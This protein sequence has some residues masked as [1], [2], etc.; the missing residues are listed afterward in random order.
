M[1]ENI[2]AI[3]NPFS[4]KQIGTENN[5][6][7]FVYPEYDTFEHKFVWKLVN[8]NDEGMPQFTC[9]VDPETVGLRFDLVTDCL[10][11]LAYMM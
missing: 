3:N 8:I 7:G 2:K 1:T 6:N 11:Q 4:A 10:N 5:F 9:E